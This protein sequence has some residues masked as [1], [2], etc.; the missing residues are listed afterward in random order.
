MS[1]KGIYSYLL[2]QIRAIQQSLRDKE[3]YKKETKNELTD[4]Q[5]DFLRN[6]RRF[7]KGKVHKCKKCGCEIIKGTS[8]C[9]KCGV[10]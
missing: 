5:L 7:G 6:Q 1:K 3:E 9:P 10:V 4:K 2:G 8:R